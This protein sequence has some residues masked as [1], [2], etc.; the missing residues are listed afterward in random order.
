MTK[1]NTLTLLFMKPIS[2]SIHLKNLKD[3]YRSRYTGLYGHLLGTLFCEVLTRSLVWWRRRELFV[4]RPH[5]CG[6]AVASL[7]R[8]LALLRSAEPGYAGLSIYAR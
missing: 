7:P 1:L 6:V 5:P 2:I 3:T 4:L 8:C